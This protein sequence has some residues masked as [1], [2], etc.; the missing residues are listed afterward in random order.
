MRLIPLLTAVLVT[1]FL[2]SIV[3]FRNDLLEFAG[4]TAQIDETSEPE[5]AEVIDDAVS[6]GAI[7]VIALKSV[8][9][10]V[11]SAVILRG[12]TQAARQVEIRSETTS[13]VVSE[14]LRKGAFV[15]AGQLM[16]ELDAGT[17][18]VAVAEAEARLAE[19]IA[20]QPETEARIPEAEAG[21]PEAQARLVEANARLAEA[22]INYR[23]AQSLQ[24][25]GFASETRVINTEAAVRSAEAGIIAAETGLKSAEAGLKAAKSGL[26][27]TRAGIQSAEAGVAAAE[28]EIDRLRITAPFDGILESDSAELGALLQPGSLCATVLQLDPIKLVGFVPE[29]EVSAV[30]INAKSMA[31]LATGE[32]VTGTVSFLAR[33]ADPTTRTF[34]V[35][36]EVPNPD[37]TIRDGQTAEIVIAAP[38]ALAHLLPQSSLTLDNHGALGVRIVDEN[39]T[40]QFVPVE[41]LRDTRDGVWLAGLPSE[42]SVITLGQEYVT[43]GVPV[44]ATYKEDVTQ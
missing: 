14:P 37:L 44:R 27:S 12:E 20:R 8:A 22:Q 31:R 18:I 36:I 29:T 26:D 4:V 21:I 24:E 32:E 42:A 13:T 35:E 28:K 1:A 43:D 15:K 33:S 40:A 30:Q 25:D 38:G 11:D 39:D 5:E 10:T 16:C 34:R 2:I 23:A 6:D 19:A 9:T 3:L 7:A 17:R 41:L